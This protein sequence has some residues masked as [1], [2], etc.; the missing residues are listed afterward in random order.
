VGP[1]VGELLEELTQGQYTGELKTRE[2][3]LVYART[4]T[5]SG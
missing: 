3:A 1:R 2:Q 5:A 4:R